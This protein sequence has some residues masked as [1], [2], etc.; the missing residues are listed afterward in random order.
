V[1]R[2][3]RSL[4]DYVDGDADVFAYRSLVAAGRMVVLLQTR[5]V[6]F[7]IVLEGNFVAERLVVMLIEDPL[8][9]A[10]DGGRELVV[11]EHAY[12]GLGR[13]CQRGSFAV[14]LWGLAAL[15]ATGAPVSRRECEQQKAG[16]GAHSPGRSKHRTGL[17][18]LGY[19]R[20]T[21]TL[22]AAR[23]IASRLRSTSSPVVAHEHTLMR[24]AVRPCQTVLPHQQVPS[25]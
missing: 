13:G 10:Y 3:G 11:F 24:I 17:R 22:C 19:A 14:A 7:A 21:P 2:G 20:A 9:D 18:P 12:L 8:S 23:S 1:R 25:S 5:H 4:F 6:A 16:A 15:T